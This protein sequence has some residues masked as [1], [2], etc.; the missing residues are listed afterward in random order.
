M[1]WRYGDSRQYEGAGPKVHTVSIVQITD[2]PA[3]GGY[4]ELALTA[5]NLGWTYASIKTS[6]GTE[7]WSAKQVQGDVSH[8]LRFF[9]SDRFKAINP[10]WQI[11]YPAIDGN[12]PG[13]SRVFNVVFIDDIDLRRIEWEVWVKEQPAGA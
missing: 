13:A 1:R 7:L 4:N 12:S 10:R 2:G 11:W 5:T 8:R 6:T 9:H 3:A